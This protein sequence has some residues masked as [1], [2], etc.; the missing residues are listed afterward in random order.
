MY[1]INFIQYLFHQKLLK[2]YYKS[3]SVFYN[4]YELQIGFIKILKIDSYL[5]HCVAMLACAYAYVL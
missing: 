4:K 5:R 3:Y 2:S 1:E